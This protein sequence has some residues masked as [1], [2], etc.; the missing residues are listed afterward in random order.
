MT[1]RRWSDEDLRY[2]EE[3]WGVYQMSKICEYLDR[4]EGSVVQKAYRL[5]LH[6]FLDSADYISYNMLLKALGYGNADTY[7]TTSWIKNRGLP[8]KYKKVNR[9]RFRIIYL[10]DFWKWAKK[11][12]DLLD[13]SR[14]EKN[15]LGK[16]PEWV[17]RKRKHDIEKKRNYKSSPW[18]KTE[19]ERLRYFLSRQQY[20]Y[21]EL[22]RMMQRTDGAI[23]R[24]AI[25]L[26]I[27]DRPIKA[28]SHNRWTESEIESVVGMIQDGYG[29]E[30]MS[31]RLERSSKAIKGKVYTIYKTENLDKVRRL[32]EKGA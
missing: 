24:R 23:L 8:I 7:K 2:L 29:Y 20:T 6:A 10:D 4:S 11:N 22:S 5:G 15:V 21:F 32:L 31:D 17:A 12:R 9:C 18:T 30:Y 1:W 16:E 28:D 3:S 13:F 19:D 26:G 25:D 14:F 27:K